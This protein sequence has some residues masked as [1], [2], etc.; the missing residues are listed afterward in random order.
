MVAKGTDTRTVSPSF[1][2]RL[3]AIHRRASASLAPEASSR[4]G[5]KALARPCVGAGR[6]RALLR[7]CK[8]ESPHSG[9]HGNGGYRSGRMTLDARVDRRV[10]PCP[11][12]VHQAIQTRF[13]R[14]RLGETGQSAC[15]S[16]RKSSAE[17]AVGQAV[18]NGRRP[19][20]IPRNFFITKTRPTRFSSC[21]SPRLLGSDP[22]GHA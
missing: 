21:K 16:R 4:A 9:I 19:Y 11:Q 20:R 10:T 3:P 7:L 18:E 17:R 22:A 13:H 15:S 6:R 1:C 8:S 2:P 12:D 14:S 5:K